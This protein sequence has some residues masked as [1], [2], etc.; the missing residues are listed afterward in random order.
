[1]ERIVNGAGLF[2]ETLQKLSADYEK[3][4]PV[5]TGIQQFKNGSKNVQPGLTRITVMFSQPLNKRNTG[6]D[7][8][9]LGEKYCPAIS[10]QGRTWSDDGRSYTFEADLKPG[11]RYQ[12]LISD[13]FRMESGVRLKPY[14]I[15]ITT[16]D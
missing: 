16:K 11:Q 7:F 1:V 10:P 9:P 2:P 12:I 13:N 8:G 6:I 4:R 15:E 3:T 5:V 14:L